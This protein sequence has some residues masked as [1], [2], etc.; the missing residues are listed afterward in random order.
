MS[1]FLKKGA[2]QRGG[3]ERTGATRNLIMSSAF[4]HSVLLYGLRLH[5]NGRDSSRKLFRTLRTKQIRGS[6]ITITTPVKLKRGRT[7]QN[8]AVEVEYYRTN[9]NIKLGKLF[10]NIGRRRRGYRVPGNVQ[11]S[12][13]KFRPE[14]IIQINR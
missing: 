8:R 12:R 2:L 3:M 11:N 7:I 13:V 9:G 1:R 4:P 5:G 10:K 6:R 14:F